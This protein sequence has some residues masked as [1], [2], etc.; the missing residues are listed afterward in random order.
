MSTLSDC[1]AVVRT[2]T[3]PAAPS[4]VTK[5][6]TGDGTASRSR[7]FI[8]LEV[9]AAMMARLSA[10]AA[11]DASRAVVTVDPFGSVV[12]QALAR[13]TAS[14]GV[15]STL[16]I[17]LTP[18]GPNR[19]LCPRASKMTLLDTTAPASMVLFG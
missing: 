5:R 17:P 13:R 19:L 6:A 2:M 10:R 14:S 1:P 7:T 18:R 12:A 8:A 9:S 3:P 4:A 15:T 11:R 16:M